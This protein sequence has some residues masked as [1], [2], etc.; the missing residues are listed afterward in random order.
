MS[1]LRLHLV[2]LIVVVFQPCRPLSPR[3]NS[4]A[5]AALFLGV[6]NSA[7][8]RCSVHPSGIAC[9]LTL[10]GRRLVSEVGTAHSGSIALR[11]TKFLFSSLLKG[12][13][14]CTSVNLPVGM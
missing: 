12:L 5:P 1:S 14:R 10:W 6:K 3:W 11:N 2:S 7:Q 8:L 13:G 9:T 4:W